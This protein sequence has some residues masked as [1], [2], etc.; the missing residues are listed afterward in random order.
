MKTLDSDLQEPPKLDCSLQDIVKTLPPECFEQNPLKAWSAVI[1]NLLLVV[2]GYFCL[3]TSPWFLLPFAWMFTGIVLAGLFVLGHDCGHYSFAKKRWVNEL[4]GQ[5]VML[6]IV[7]PFHNWRIHHNTHHKFTNKLGEG[8]WK[9]LLAVVQ[10]KV[11]IA[12]F[13]LRKEVWSSIKPRERFL[14][15]FWREKLWWLESLRNWWYEFNLKKFTLSERERRQ[16]RLSVTVVIVFAGFVSFTLILAAGVWGLIKFWLVPWLIFHFWLSIITRFHHTS[17]DI[18]WKSE[19]NW[20][21][22]QAQLRGTIYCHYP[23]WIEF[24]WHDINVHIPHHLTS[25]IPHY[26][27]RK[28]HKSLQQ[29]WGAY[30]KECN[31][32]WTLFRQMGSLNLYDPDSECY[33]SFQELDEGSDNQKALI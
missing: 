8:R 29:N 31:F 13:P 9:Q 6:P 28:A 23:R 20:D 12:W 24:L 26:N 17:P 33:L 10:R 32:S 5:L 25:A 11:D 4:V 27:L 18:P 22:A 19:K 16:V 15:R 7:Y 2:L 21:I 3:S 1:V 14:Y 30:L